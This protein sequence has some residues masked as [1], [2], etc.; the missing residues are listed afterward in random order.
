MALLMLL[1]LLAR[2]EWEAV[3]PESRSARLMT[4]VTGALDAGLDNLWRHP[5]A[6]RGQ[7]HGAHQV[8][9]AGGEV[10]LAAAKLARGVVKRKRVVVVVEALSWKHE[11]AN[12][13]FLNGFKFGS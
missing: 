6:V 7:P 13:Y 4:A 8:N 9:E 12:Y 5:L 11:M 1:L 2:G 3:K 10:Q